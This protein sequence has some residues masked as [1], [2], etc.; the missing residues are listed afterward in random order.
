MRNFITL[1]NYHILVK[2]TRLFQKY[3]KKRKNKYTEILYREKNFEE[4]ANRIIGEKILNGKPFLVARFGSTEARTIH[5][6]LIQKENY[7]DIV[8]VYKHLT[9]N[10][11]EYWNFW[12]LHTNPIGEFCNGAGFFPNNK[13][14]MADFVEIYKHAASKLDILAVWNGYEEF[15]PGVPEELLLCG[16][17]DIEPWFSQH[18]WTK[19]LEGKSVLIVHPF[20][21]TIKSQYYNFRTEIFQNKEI[22]P[23]F[24]LKIIKAVQSIADEKEQSYKDWFHALNIMKEQIKSENFDIAII[25]CGAYGF[26]LAAYVKEIGK[27]AIHLGGVTQLLFGIKGK[28]WEKI[29]DYHT[30]RGD[31][32]VYASEIPKGF[33]KVEGGRYW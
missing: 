3:I 22:L 12:N 9:G 28:G 19:F 10:L 29:P 15:M 11:K 18:P 4:T 17:R 1:N 20:D 25:G 24:E 21:N 8:G 13:K 14:L 5:R 6:F 16:L 30:F 27:Q 26:P 23:N 32:W 31:A 33:Q 7:N 2:F